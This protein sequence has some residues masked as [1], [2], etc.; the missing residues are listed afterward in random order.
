VGLA[1]SHDP[2][3][4]TDGSAATG[5]ASPA[6]QV[7]GDEPDEKRFP[8]PPSWGFGVGLKTPC[9]KKYVLLRSF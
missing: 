8:G 2:A 9:L 4:Y 6:G 3:S 7:K 1:L 5:G